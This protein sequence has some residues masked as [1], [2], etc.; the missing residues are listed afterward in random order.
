MPRCAAGSKSTFGRTARRSAASGFQS[1]QFRELEFLS[2]AKDPTYVER[3]KG[4]TAVE[5]ESSIDI[6]TMVGV[7]REE[8][9]LSPI[10]FAVRKRLPWLNINLAT[11]FLAAS[12][13][14]IFSSIIDRFTALAVLLPVVAGQSGNTGAQALAVHGVPRA[15]GD[16]DVW[17]ERSPEN[18]ARVWRALEAF[19]APAAA[20]TC[21]PVSRA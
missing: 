6:Q 17:I 5:Q 12:V 2:G 8:R 4:L 13:V 18:A 11:A 15:T 16:I 19:G 20:S 10:A 14:G 3:F 9:A 1:V 21:S 7:S